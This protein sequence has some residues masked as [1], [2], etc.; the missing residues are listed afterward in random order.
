MG[1]AAGD[2]VGFARAWVYRVHL[3]WIVKTEVPLEPGQYY[4]LFNRGVNRTDI[5]PEERNFWY[6]MQ[7]YTKHLAPLVDT[8]A[9]CLMR[10]HFHYLVRI[11]AS[12]RELNPRGLGDPAGLCT[13]SRDLRGLQD[14][15]G[16]RSIDRRMVVQAVSNWLNAYAKAI[17]KAYERTGP[18]F[19]HRLGRRAITSD[20][21]F[22]TLVQYIHY[23]PQKHGFEK[24]YRNWF[25]SSYRALL[26]DS[27]TLIERDEVLGWFGGRE[28]LREFHSSPA[29]DIAIGA[30]VRDDT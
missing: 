22:A 26:S 21:Y 14:P 5:F 29:D 30:F 9:Y 25:Y 19:E 12:R 23:N 24:D 8:F 10:N 2:P 3:E 11:R 7:L 20:R 28:A 4:H 27:Y 6:F 16:L 17:N 1:L 15:V 13:H 18:L